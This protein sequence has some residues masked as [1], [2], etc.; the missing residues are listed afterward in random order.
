MT[1]QSILS[2]CIA[3][4]LAAP[5]VLAAAPAANGLS[6]DAAPR[7]GAQVAD[8]QEAAIR[9]AMLAYTNDGMPLDL[10]VDEPEHVRQLRENLTPLKGAE[11]VDPWV[12]VLGDTMWGPLDMGLM[13]IVFQGHPLYSP[14]PGVLEFAGARVCLYDVDLSPCAELYGSV[15]TVEAGDGLLGGN[16]TKSGRIS[17][18][19][20]G[21]D[22]TKLRNASVVS[23]KLAP[24]AVTTPKIA[25]LAITGD[26]LA[27][28]AVRAEKIL[29][30]A[31]RTLHLADGAVTTGKLADLAVTA[32]K[33]LAGAVRGNHILDG[34]VQDVDLADA[35]VTANKLA[36]LSV[37]SDKLAESIVRTNHIL[38]GSITAADIADGAIGASKLAT[39]VLNASH[40]AD[41]AV[42]AAK[43]G[44]GAVTE[45]AIAP[46]SISASK[47]ANLA[48]T[49]DKIVASA[50][51]GDH[52]LDGSVSAADIADGAVTSAKLSAGILNTSHIADSAVTAAKL[53]PGAVTEIAIASGSI[54]AAKLADAVVTA[55][56]IA[57]SAI[58][59]AKLG[60]GSVT[61]TAL[62][63]DAVTTPKLLDGAVT[64][65]KLAD[66]SVAAAKLAED[67]VTNAKIRD[68]AVSTAKLA[69][70]SVRTAKLEDAAV[71]AAKLAAGAVT[72]D[73]LATSFRL[74]WSRIVDLPA[75][76]ADAVD[77]DKLEA[78]ACA[79]GQ[80]VK[81]L[82]GLWSCSAQIGAGA[83]LTQSGNALHLA[84]ANVTTLGGVLA[85]DCGY[86]RVLKAID[87]AGKA[88]C[89]P[90]SSRRAGAQGN[91]IQ[92][93]EVYATAPEPA[94]AIG[95]DGLP[96]F[97][98]P[99][100]GN[101]G[102]R[103]GRCVDVRC[104]TPATL[105]TLD[106][107]SASYQVDII[108]GANGFPL[109]A[110][111][112]WGT[113]RIVR[114]LDLA[115]DSIDATSIGSGGGDIS[116]GLTREGYPLVATHGWNGV[117]FIACS[118]ATCDGPANELNPSMASAPIGDLTLMMGA[119]GNPT[120]AFFGSTYSSYAVAVA[121]CADVWCS[122]MDEQIYEVQ[123]DGNV[124][125]AVGQD[126]LPI[127][128]F[129]QFASWS[130]PGNVTALHC[131]LLSC[132]NY[133]IS[134][135]R[136]DATGNV[137]V[138][139]TDD[140]RPVIALDGWPAPVFMRCPRATCETAG[141]NGIP[142]VKI[143]EQGAGSIAMAIGAD[144]L[145]LLVYA[146]GNG[147][148][149]AHLGSVYGIG[150]ANW[151]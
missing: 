139:V 42:T 97:A 72:N 49:G 85:H 141:P 143:E 96:I 150:Y 144:G 34:T 123:T 29:S 23:D 10:P 2:I 20:E 7:A 55:N 48:I 36:N 12:D 63:S 120:V 9:A 93:H 40:I 46:G 75:G 119:D 145:P 102:V 30:G 147:L 56:K 94:V 98:Y 61:S 132:A 5:I 148:T 146:G 92:S 15:K 33:I 130:S 107:S 89:G 32:E 68:G 26:K 58:T 124:A 52:I 113:I 77:N 70:A 129:T 86:A 25:D 101:I 18:A 38:D 104:Q 69:D 76:F 51:R 138:A 60:L 133:T 137:A 90:E 112:D 136:D 28:A 21:V 16:I 8:A 24:G 53:G 13:P 80:I 128:V 91:T 22:A 83:G 39:G 11:G 99:A 82:L 59:F 100:D 151:R 41:G 109:I 125:A 43:L 79:D 122:L 87:T 6:A 62:A 131:S 114:C 17:I 4:L 64:T 115:C 110:T 149:T 65:P 81:R 140:G 84:P 47:L 106:D 66:A 117:R 134:E 74:A 88:V 135:L 50:V 67:A 57:D 78:L 73:S 19:P 3:L 105:K 121:H 71:T 31:I 118:N 103:F 45:A 27:D 127:V 14:R 116:L 111:M 44:P 95:S 54:T 37:T 1:R 142:L 35:A 108:V 126:G